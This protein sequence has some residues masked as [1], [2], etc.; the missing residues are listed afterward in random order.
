M[1]KRKFTWKKALVI[2]AG[3]LV[4]AAVGSFL[5]VRMTESPEFCA[6]CHVMKP[7]YETHFHS[8]HRDVTC[9]DCHTPQDNYLKKVAYKGMSG[10]WDAYVFFTGQSP[11]IFKTKPR[12]KE[13][14]HANCVRCHWK[15]VDAIEKRGGKKCFECH[16][17]TPHGEKS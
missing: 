4:F 8:A 7:M 15:V 6:S 11:Q 17:Y 3:L 12:T 5:T 16:R 10:T 1:A 14:L 9:N 13:I 2:L